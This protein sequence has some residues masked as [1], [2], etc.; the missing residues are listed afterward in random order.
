MTDFWGAVLNPVNWV[1]SLFSVSATPYKRCT[2]CTN[3]IRYQEWRTY[4]PRFNRR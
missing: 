4:S 3:G 2:D 1:P